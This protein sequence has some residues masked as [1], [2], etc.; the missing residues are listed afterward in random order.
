V[1]LMRYDP[2]PATTA[3]KVVGVSSSMPAISTTCDGVRAS[4]R[5]CVCTCVC[6]WHHFIT[7]PEGD[8]V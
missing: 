5:A 6:V 7:P 1:R 8:S 2:M 3:A 4:V